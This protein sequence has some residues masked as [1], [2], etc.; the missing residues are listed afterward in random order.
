VGNLNGDKGNGPEHVVVLLPDLQVGFWP[1]G[2]WSYSRDIPSNDPLA[3]ALSMDTE[4]Q[5]TKWQ[6]RTGRAPSFDHLVGQALEALVRGDG[7][8]SG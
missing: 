7:E 3:L 2:T 1:D 6:L 4:L 5:L 8:S